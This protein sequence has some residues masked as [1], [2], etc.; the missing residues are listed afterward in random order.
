MSCEGGGNLHS[1]D[2][3]QVGGGVL[4]KYAC[5]G[6]G[7]GG[8]TLVLLVISWLQSRLTC[9]CLA[10]RGRFKYPKVVGGWS[11]GNVGVVWF[12]VLCKHCGVKGR[13]GEASLS[14]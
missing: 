14:L 12:G 7:D 13:H 2:H 3:V 1:S 11:G 6:G 9:L 5:F 4:I 8:G 10:E